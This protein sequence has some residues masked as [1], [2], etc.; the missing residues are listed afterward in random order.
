MLYIMWLRSY[1]S[2]HNLALI[3]N[4]SV[5]TVH[6]EINKYIPIIKR[7]VEHFVQWPTINEWREKRCSW[8]KLESAVGVIDSTSTAIYHPQIEPHELYFSGHR[9]FHAIVIG[10]DGY[11]CYAEVR[12]LGH[13][14]DPQQFTMMQQIGVNGPLHFW[15]DFVLLTDKIYPNR[16]PTVTL[17][18]TQPKRKKKRKKKRK[19]EHMR[20]RSIFIR[21]LGRCISILGIYS[22]S[23]IH[24]QV[25]YIF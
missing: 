13:Q 12:F 5:A 18:T 23:C 9:H 10:N 6:N 25:K 2:Y 11:I 24:P 8:T 1:P 20:N 4:V 22:F 14:N 19:P 7:S 16:H 15:E 21:L 3:F 17:F